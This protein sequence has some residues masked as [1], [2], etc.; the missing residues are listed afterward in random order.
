[1][2]RAESTASGAGAGT[3][4]SVFM[5]F[6]PRV[7]TA[8]RTPI[9]QIEHDGM[10]VSP[11]GKTRDITAILKAS[12]PLIHPQLIVESGDTVHIAVNG[13]V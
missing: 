4:C 11:P 10:S 9:S 5:G 8:T 1:M 12:P 3:D 7:I 2:T 6:D 13:P